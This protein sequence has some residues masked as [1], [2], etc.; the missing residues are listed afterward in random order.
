MKYNLNSK[1]HQLKDYNV[2]ISICN[3]FNDENWN[4]VSKSI[5]NRVCK[6][7]IPNKNEGKLK[8]DTI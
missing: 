6:I 5:Q 4:T 2:E 7:I 1:Y 8:Y 3:Q